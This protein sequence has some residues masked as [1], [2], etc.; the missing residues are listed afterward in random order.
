MTSAEK[1]EIISKIKVTIIYR[2]DNSFIFFKIKCFRF[3]LN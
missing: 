1:T 2:N 3:L